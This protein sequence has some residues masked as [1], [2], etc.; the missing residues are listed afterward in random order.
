MLTETMQWFVRTLIAFSLLA[1]VRSRWKSRFIAFFRR[2]DPRRDKIPWSSS[3]SL[4]LI[5]IANSKKV[6]GLSEP[7]LFEA[8]ADRDERIFSN[9][10]FQPR[11]WKVLN[12]VNPP[13]ENRRDCRWIS[14]Y[15]TR[16][17]MI[18][19]AERDPRFYV[20]SSRWSDVP[21]WSETFLPCVPQSSCSALCGLS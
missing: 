2:I 7:P 19:S 20:K 11:A 1:R 9:S 10:V 5:I 6:G 21:K 4:V 14:L 12:L 18:F 15:D 17:L 8:M 13:S 3:S 16:D